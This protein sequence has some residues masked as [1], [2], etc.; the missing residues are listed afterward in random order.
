MPKFLVTCCVTA[1]PS[2]AV[3]SNNKCEI[4]ASAKFCLH[5]ARH[6][7]ELHRTSDWVHSSRVPR[8][9]D[10]IPGKLATKNA[11]IVF[12]VLSSIENPSFVGEG[13]TRAARDSGAGKGGGRGSA[14][15]RWAAP[16]LRATGGLKG[17]ASSCY[18]PATGPRTLEIY[19]QNIFLAA[20]TSTHRLKHR[21]ML[22]KAA[23]PRC[24]RGYNLRL[25][26]YGNFR[27]IT[28]GKKRGR[29][30]GLWPTS[31]ANKS[32]TRLSPAFTSAE[33]NG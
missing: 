19:G 30:R 33:Q 15:G 25:K 12:R 24:S 10:R 26:R 27:E 21:R 1:M 29:Q 31:P 7:S 32:L 28:H 13:H 23:R 2:S 9:R 20:R 8:S 6:G 4:W 5:H 16:P 11:Q 18:A 17:P 22:V 14:A 3:S